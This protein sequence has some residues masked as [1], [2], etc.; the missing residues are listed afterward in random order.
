[1]YFPATQYCSP[2]WRS[3]PE[4][5]IIRGLREKADSILQSELD[6]TLRRL[7]DLTPQQQRAIT[8]MGQSIVN[9]LLHDPF[10]CL[11]NPP[12]NSADMTT[13]ELVQTV[14]G[15]HIENCS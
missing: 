12:D 15:L 10:T 13:Y 9:K 2:A 4:A 3:I 14:F 5:P 6:L 1:M 7:G 11:K 8:L